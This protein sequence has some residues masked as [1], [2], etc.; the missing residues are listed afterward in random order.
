[1]QNIEERALA[2]C[3]QTIQ[4]RLSYV[5]DTFTAVHKHDID[6]FHK[7]FNKR[8]A[9]I[10]FFRETKKTEVVL[11]S[12]YLVRL[13]INKLK[14]TAYRKPTQTVKNIYYYH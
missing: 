9:D 11:F 12:D 3:P 7:H 1:M 10:Q 13:D 4:L 5:D 8:H 2:T 6:A 14:I